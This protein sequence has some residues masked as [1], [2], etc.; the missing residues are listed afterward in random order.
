MI[1]FTVRNF[2][3]PGIMA[4]FHLANADS[5][6]SSNFVSYSKANQSVR[7]AAFVGQIRN[8]IKARSAFGPAPWVGYW[9]WQYTDNTAEGNNWGLVTIKDN[10]YDGHEAVSSTVAC[11][12]PIN[13][14][15]CGGE[16]ANFGNVIAPVINANAD[17]DHAIADSSGSSAATAQ[18]GTPGSGSNPK[19]RE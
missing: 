10:A 1:D 8:A 2:G 7:G 11:S 13:S 15:T 5:P 9:W 6:Y 16:A 4:T 12:S 18:T 17:I 3:K 19:K 14:F